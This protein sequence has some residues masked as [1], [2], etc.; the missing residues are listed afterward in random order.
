[1]NKLMLEE[2]NR[3][4]EIMGVKQK[5]IN[6]QASIV[7]D[8]LDFVAKSPDPKLRS[9]LDD[10]V[11]KAGKAEYKTLDD[12]IRDSGKI[13]IEKVVPGIT[14][15]ILDAGMKVAP[16]RV[17]TAVLNSIFSR[18]ILADLIT[19]DKGALSQDEFNLLYNRIEDT[20]DKIS[21][22]QI[23]DILTDSKT[24]QRAINGLPKNSKVKYTIPGGR[25]VK[26]GSEVAGDI[27]VADD[28]GKG[29][30]ASVPEPEFVGFSEEEFIKAIQSEDPI[31]EAVIESKEVLRDVLSKN[32]DFGKR[33]S[34]V[35]KQGQDRVINSA[36]S[37]ISSD[38]RF[39]EAL[40][41]FNTDDEKFKTVI[42]IFNNSSVEGEIKA[43][44]LA[45]SLEKLPL[46]YKLNVFKD[47]NKL[48]DILFYR[49]L[50]S[51][52]WKVKNLKKTLLTYFAINATLATM[53]V[54][55]NGYYQE[56]QDP[57]TWDDSWFEKMKQRF[58]IDSFVTKILPTPPLVALAIDQGMKFFT[59]TP[60]RTPSFEE[61]IT[62]MK[63]NNKAF[64]IT[65]KTQMTKSK[66]TETSY[67]EKDY[68]SAI[69]SFDDAQKQ[70]ANVFKRASD[71]AFIG[72]FIYNNNEKKVVPI[73]EGTP[74]NKDETP[75]Q[76]S[77]ISETEDGL[78]EVLKQPIDK[79]GWGDNFNTYYDGASKTG[80]YWTIKLKGG[81]ESY[82]IYQNG[83]FVQS[84]SND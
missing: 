37:S 10:F 39:K 44:I 25:S 53:E 76:T 6:E 11:S 67:G 33:F 35:S 24:I 70:F 5:L 50:N 63:E 72:I 12:L 78:K 47:P 51:G 64:G 84:K 27:K 61:V 74:P 34:K 68:T 38:K 42:E 9:G 43:E 21:D 30:D 28:V 66:V 41:K 40:M 65:D 17:K 15:K 69:S 75:T 19:F 59:K 80:N 77:T 32:D 62:W 8:V 1:M 55:F 31:E 36:I 4:S 13:D 82:Y 26:T 54:A 83:T 20:I 57:D 2:I 81:G 22:R 49:D 58:N 18:E 7:D 45:N 23:L 29:V 48:L 14:K 79:G 52:R 60:Y 71:G 46:K 3:I 16:N 73:I 56:N